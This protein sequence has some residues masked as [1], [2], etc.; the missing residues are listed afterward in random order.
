MNRIAL[1]ACAASMTMLTLAAAPVAIE[2][3]NVV[4]Q[5]QMEKFSTYPTYDGDDLELAIDRN[6]YHF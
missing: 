2:A 5:T 1:K 3:Q 4:T 6:G